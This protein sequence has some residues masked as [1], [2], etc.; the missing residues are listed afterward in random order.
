MIHIPWCVLR[1][2]LNIHLLYTYKKVNDV[3]SWSHRSH[4]TGLC[5]TLPSSSVVTGPGLMSP[6][7]PVSLLKPKLRLRCP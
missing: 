5:L 3:V 6:E 2:P 1:Q 4:F 7:P